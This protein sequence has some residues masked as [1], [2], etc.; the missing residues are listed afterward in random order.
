M[1][2]PSHR[3]RLRLGTTL[4][5]LNEL[6]AGVDELKRSCRL[7]ER[8][9]YQIQLVLDELV[10]NAISYGFA[11]GKG[12]GIDIDIAVW[13]DRRCE[14]TY[15]DDAPAFDPFSSEVGSRES[16]TE[17]THFGGFGIS[18]VKKLMDRVTYRYDKG[19]NYLVMQKQL[20]DFPAD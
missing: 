20:S 6:A 16:C 8:D 12:S 10:T 9:G 3:K 5:A 17:K 18:L 1:T 7:T 14:I 15:C 11:T 2:E 19:K 13:P 4:D